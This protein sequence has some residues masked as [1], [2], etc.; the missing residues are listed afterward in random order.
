[1][2]RR[3]LREMIWDCVVGFLSGVAFVAF[4]MLVLHL[5]RIDI[6]GIF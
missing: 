5:I 6:I 4:A 3:K 2:N 1:M